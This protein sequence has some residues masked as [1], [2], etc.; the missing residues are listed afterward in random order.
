ML[1]PRN[2]SE[3]LVRSGES[4][5]AQPL[6]IDVE[7]HAW[8]RLH[9]RSTAVDRV[10]RCDHPQPRAAISSRSFVANLEQKIPAQRCRILLSIPAQTSRR[11][12]PRDIR[13]VSAQLSSSGK[14]ELGGGMGGKGGLGRACASRDPLHEN[15]R[16]QSELE[17]PPFKP[18]LGMAA[19]A[20]YHR[21]NRGCPGKKRAKKAQVVVYSR[22]NCS[23]LSRGG[24]SSSDGGCGS[25]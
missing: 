8:L 18:P 7:R 23:L 10:Q 14:T 6:S 5:L 17:V 24:G 3:S 2:E 19:R 20:T 21:P 12:I 22:F 11:D 13:W 9:Q 16:T 4:M 1:P 25:W 15:S